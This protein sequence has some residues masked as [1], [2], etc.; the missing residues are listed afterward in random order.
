MVHML[1]AK[2][3]TV[4]SSKNENITINRNQ[5]SSSKSSLIE[6][7][8]KLFS[9]EEHLLLT[10]PKWF[11]L[12]TKSRHE[13]FVEK[14]LTE[15]GIESFTPTV[16]L[17]KKWSDRIKLIEQPLFKSYCFA[18]FPLKDKTKIVSE[19]GVVHIVHFKN[20]YVSVED[21]VID[22][23]KILAKN[24][25]QIEPHPYLKIGKRVRLKTG[26]LRGVEGYIMEKRNKNTTIVLSIEA[27]NSSVSCVVDIDDVTE[28]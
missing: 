10:I 22:S 17:R 27:I 23:L 11:A 19:P 28:A 12:Y 7:Q 1:T 5:N 13:K 6:K 3:T 14:R 2:Q 20:E 4:Y 24:K 8:G 26:P 15:K 9:P 25:I 21:E 18:K 16:L